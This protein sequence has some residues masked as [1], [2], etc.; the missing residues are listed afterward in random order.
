[1]EKASNQINAYR[2]PKI[3]P[4]WAN[5]P[6]KWFATVEAS[7]QVAKITDDTTKFHIILANADTAILSHIKDLIR[8]PPKNGKFDALKERVLNVFS[9]S[10]GARLRQL[11]KGQV[12]GEKKPSHFLQ[13]LK[14][15][16]GDQATDNIIKTLFIE[17]L[18]ENYRTILATIEESELSKLAN[19]ADKIAESTSLNTTVDPVVSSKLEDLACKHTAQISLVNRI[20]ENAFLEQLVQGMNVLLCERKQRSRSRSPNNSY[21]STRK[22]SQSRD[23]D[24]KCFYHR[25]FGNKAHRCQQPCSWTDDKSN[26]EN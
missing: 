12:L 3:P 24:G 7:F 18:P 25:R 19:I 20:S 9:I 8:N 11:L 16:A 5:D 6:E 21:R 22:R 15:L 26:Q 1:M 17:Q 14:N 10:Q 4:F 13:E 2:V 23:K